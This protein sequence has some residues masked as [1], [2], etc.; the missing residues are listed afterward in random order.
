MRTIA[1]AMKQAGEALDKIANY[2][3]LPMEEIEKL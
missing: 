1:L 2:T 3:H